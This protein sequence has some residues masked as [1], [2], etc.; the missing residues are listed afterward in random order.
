MRLFGLSDLVTDFR[1][2][3]SL[4]SQ[5]DS[6]F[7]TDD[8]KASVW[9]PHVA[10][11][12]LPVQVEQSRDQLAQNEI[13]IDPF[14]PDELKR[15]RVWR[16]S[17]DPHLFEMLLDKEQ[18]RLFTAH[19]QIMK[20]QSGLAQ[21][22]YNFFSQTIGRRNRTALGQ[23]EN[24]FFLK[25]SELHNILWPT[26][27]YHRFEEEFTQ[28]MK[29]YSPAWDHSLTLNVSK[30]FGY[31]FT[32]IN[33]APEQKKPELWIRVERDREDELNGDQSYFNRVL[34]KV[35]PVTSA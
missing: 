13:D 33:K 5:Y 20:E 31:Q 7:F 8:D 17:L 15:V 30:M 9:T 6:D 4:K 2:I 1:F 27:K 19:S 26:R 29:R 12:M 28:V 25:L 22:I 18:R 34:N 14:N 23:K 32:L 16:I 35:S 3:S 10:A 24:V 21:T 11:G